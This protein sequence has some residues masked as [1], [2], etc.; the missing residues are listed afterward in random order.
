MRKVVKFLSAI[1]TPD[2]FLFAFVIWFPI[3]K[4]LNETERSKT[5]RLMVARVGFEP[6]SQPYEGHKET[7]PPSRNI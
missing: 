7:S 3:D 4:S 2:A 1:F 6:T 5:M